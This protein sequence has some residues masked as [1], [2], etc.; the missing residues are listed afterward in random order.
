[1]R[2]KPRV[3]TVVPADLIRGEWT[4]A[5]PQSKIAYD[6]DWIIDLADGGHTFNV[7][8]TAEYQEFFEPTRASLTFAGAIV[9]VGEAED[10]D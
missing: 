3:N 1:M 9:V 2:N 6:L 8:F 5:S 4:W 10:G 7:G